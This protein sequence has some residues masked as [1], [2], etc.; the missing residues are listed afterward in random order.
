MNVFSECFDTNSDA[1][2]EKNEIFVAKNENFDKMTRFDVKKNEKIIDR[3]NEKNEINDKVFDCDANF[4]LTNKIV[5]DSENVKNSKQRISTFLYD[6]RKY[7]D[8]T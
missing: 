8:E 5:I 1:K 2:L 4:E 3:K 6:D 7:V